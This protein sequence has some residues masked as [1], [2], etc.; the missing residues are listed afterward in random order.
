L[1]KIRKKDGVRTY[2]RDAEL[3][4]VRRKEIIDRAAEIFNS[5]GYNQTNMRELAEAMKMS[6]GSIYHYVGS[7]QDILYLIIHKVVSRA[8][9][10][11]LKIQA[12]LETDNATDVLKGFIRSYYTEI[13]NELAATLFTYQ[14]YRN[15]EAK[16]QKF[17]RDSAEKDVEAC[18]LILRKGSE[19]GE[20][21]AVNFLVVAHNIMV[22]GH[23][24]ALRRW[25]LSTVCSLEEYIEEQIET[26]LSRI[27]K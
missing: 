9:E 3:V 20:F 22:L 1:R 19:N 16:W 25:Y 24:W 6:V 15:L 13:E 21:K 17:L 27:R 7:K 8:E 26:A 10:R 18:A 23:M 14:E 2:S 4:D 5:G 12:R 11:R